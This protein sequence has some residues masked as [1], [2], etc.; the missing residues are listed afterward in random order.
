MIEI[1][2]S[3]RGIVGGGGTGSQ[4]IT[5]YIESY[6]IATLEEA[7]FGEL[8]TTRST[9]G[10]V[11]ANSWNFCWWSCSSADSS[12]SRTLDFIQYVSM[13]RESDTVDFGEILHCC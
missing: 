13:Q 3:T 1:S 10:I 9:G 6:Q 2:N 4:S 8:S 7:R 5:K 12:P 11:I